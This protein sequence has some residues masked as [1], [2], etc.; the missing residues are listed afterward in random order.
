M[1]FLLPDFPSNFLHQ[2]AVEVMCFVPKR[3]NDMMNVGRLQGFEVRHAFFV[4][5]DEIHVKCNL[6]SM[7]MFT[8][9]FRG[10]SRLRGSCSSRTPFLSASRKA[11][12]C[13]EPRRGG[14]SCLSSW[15]C[16]VSQLIRRK[17]FHCQGT[18]SKTASRCE[19]I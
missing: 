14:S 1:L 19:R 15:S 7:A 6:R 10:K 2:K 18:L 11:A 16:S 17:A 4:V 8:L 9:C 5:T 3:C 12:S 13:P